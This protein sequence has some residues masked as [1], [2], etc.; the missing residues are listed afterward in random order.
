[1]AG[2]FFER[3]IRRVLACCDLDKGGASRFLIADFLTLEAAVSGFFKRNR[4]R[5][6]GA[7][8]RLETS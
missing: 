5:E 7:S 1:V 2:L 4:P 6:L 8:W 3:H